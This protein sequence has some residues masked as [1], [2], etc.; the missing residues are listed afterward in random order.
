MDDD[1]IDLVRYAIDDARL[2][3]RGEMSYEDAANS[4]RSLLA[5]LMTREPTDANVKDVLG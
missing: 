5:E 1:A 4:T 2:Y 3:S